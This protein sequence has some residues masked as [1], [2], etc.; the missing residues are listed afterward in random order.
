MI[1]NFIK[2]AWRN[3][4]QNKLYSAII[5]YLNNDLFHFVLYKMNSNLHNCIT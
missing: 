1:R 5:S 4:L 2:I 3:M